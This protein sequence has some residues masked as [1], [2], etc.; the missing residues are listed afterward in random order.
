MPSACVFKVEISDLRLTKSVDVST[1]QNM[2]RTSPAKPGT[3]LSSA[4][5]FRLCPIRFLP[6]AFCLPPFAF[7]LQL[8]AYCLLPSAY[9]F[10][11]SA[12]TAHGLPN[13]EWGA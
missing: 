1:R 5:R 8:S 3:T 2:D 11:P 12:R 10:P 13:Q 4:L 7:R 6:S 9:C